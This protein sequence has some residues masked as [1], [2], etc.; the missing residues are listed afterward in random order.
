RDHLLDRA[1]ALGGAEGAAEVLLHHHVGG[2][3]APGGGELHPLLLEEHLAV[4]AGNG[5]VA[6]LPG[7]LVEGVT[8]VRGEVAREGQ[9]RALAPARLGAGGTGGPGVLVFSRVPLELLKHGSP[10][11]HAASAQVCPDR[12]ACATR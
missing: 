5:G 12:W 8:T 11:P 3:L 7:E 10:S 9:A 2:G 1:L 6:Q 4:G